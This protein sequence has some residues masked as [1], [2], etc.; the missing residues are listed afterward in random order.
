M[1]AITTSPSAV[2]RADAA[3]EEVRE[4][5]VA[6]DQVIEDVQP[7]LERGRAAGPLVDGW[8]RRPGH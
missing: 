3:G 4:K 1:E 5:L 8:R 7:A 2:L 6:L